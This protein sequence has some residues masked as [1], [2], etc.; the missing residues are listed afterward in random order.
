MEG[1]VGLNGSLSGLFVTENEVDPNVEVLADVGTFEGRPVFGDEITG[2]VSQ[3][4]QND[5]SDPS[6]FGDLPEAEVVSI[7]KKVR[8]R[9]E[10]RNQLPEV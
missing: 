9:K 2:I 8:K 5:V 4:W 1:V 6:V 7:Q 10:F 3:G